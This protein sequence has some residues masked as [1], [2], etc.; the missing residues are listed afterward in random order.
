MA[1]DEMVGWHHQLNG[2][3]FEEI[4]GDS[5]GQGSL[6]CC[7]S[8]SCKESDTAE[9]LS[10]NNNGNCIFDLMRNCQTIFPSGWSILHPQQR[11][12]MVAIFLL[13][14]QHLLLSVFF[15][16]AVLVSVRRYLT[17]VLVCIFLMMDDVGHLV[18]CLLAICLSSS[19][20]CLSKSFAYF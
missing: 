5:E 19:E 10:Y 7:R 16:T 3:E 12:M 8:W 20:R 2:H 4:L 15:I 18:W 11:C 13:P 1:E 9:R 6:V 14:C 17:V